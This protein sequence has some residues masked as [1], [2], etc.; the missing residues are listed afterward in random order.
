MGANALTC[1]VKGGHNKTISFLLERQIDFDMIAAPCE[2][3]AMFVSA[4]LGRDASLRLLSDRGMYELLS[5]AINRH[6]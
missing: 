6:S 5:D 1:A 4:L 2:L 3:T